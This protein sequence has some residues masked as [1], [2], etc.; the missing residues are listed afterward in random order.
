LIAKPIDRTVNKKV[1][2]K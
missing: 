2:R 1:A